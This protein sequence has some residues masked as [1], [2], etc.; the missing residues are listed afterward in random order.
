MRPSRGNDKS[1]QTCRYTARYNQNPRPCTFVIAMFRCK[2]P[3][4]QR[5]LAI[6]AIRYAFLELIYPFF[7]RMRDNCVVLPTIEFCFSPLRKRIFFLPT[8]PYPRFAHSGVF[9]SGQF[10]HLNRYFRISVIDFGKL[11]KIGA[12]LNIEIK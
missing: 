10:Y 9:Y 11:T 6:I 12:I 1:Q 3:L 5:N 4:M 8:N 7:G 2:R